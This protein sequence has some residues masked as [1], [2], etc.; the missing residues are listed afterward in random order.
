MISKE[1]GS[2]IVE[3]IIWMFVKRINSLS[4]NNSSVTWVLFKPWV[5]RFNDKKFKENMLCACCSGGPS[6]T[7]E[8]REIC[9]LWCDLIWPGATSPG[10]GATCGKLHIGVT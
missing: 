5:Y 2:W 10:T 3:R 1:R 8:S 9:S 4:E 7:C 6:A